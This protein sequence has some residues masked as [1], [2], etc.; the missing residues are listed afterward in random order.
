MASPASPPSGHA[1]VLSGEHGGAQAAG[2]P[3]LRALRNWHSAVALWGLHGSCCC[4]GR[5]LDFLGCRWG[6]AGLSQPRQAWLSCGAGGTRGAVQV[7]GV[8]SAS[9]HP[10]WCCGA[11]KWLGPCFCQPSQCSAAQAGLPPC[12]SSPLRAHRCALSG[13]SLTWALCGRILNCAEPRSHRPLTNALR[14]S[15]ILSV[16]KRCCCRIPWAGNEPCSLRTAGL[17]GA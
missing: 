4:T 7:L 2:C 9:S 12:S 16:S 3:L 6:L 11:G 14:H 17:Q 1:P 8:D 15:L 5:Q 10:L 13:C